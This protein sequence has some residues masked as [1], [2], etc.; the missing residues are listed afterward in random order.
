MHENDHE[1]SV[2]WRRMR[3][4]L[5]SNSPRRM[6][7][8]TERYDEVVQRGL[9]DVDESPPSGPVDHQVLTI[10]QRK[11][12]AI[13]A[14][15]PSSVVVVADTM[16]ADP[17]DVSLSMGKPRDLVHAATML[18][19]LQGRHHQVWTATGVWSLGEWRFWCESATVAFPQFSH[20]EM[21]RLLHSGSWRGKAG[22][23]D[24]HGEMGQHATLVDGQACV[25]L[26]LAQSALDWLD[27]LVQASGHMSG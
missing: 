19:R 9:S 23:Y 10:C 17:D 22:A 26:G 5:A 25:V 18:H 21:D 15:E 14:P 20:A 27:D 12:A 2:V 6:A 16:I 7:M 13:A 11:A 8:L 1:R 24:L 4:Q 3:I